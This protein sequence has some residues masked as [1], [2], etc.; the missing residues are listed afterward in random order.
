MAKLSV[1]ES[2]ELLE[3]QTKDRQRFIRALAEFL[4]GNQ[5]EQSIGLQ[6]GKQSAKDWAKLRSATPLFGYPTVDEAFPVLCAFLGVSDFVAD[7]T[8]GA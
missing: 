7:R 1:K 3:R 4:V 5:V 8:G 6:L 2:I